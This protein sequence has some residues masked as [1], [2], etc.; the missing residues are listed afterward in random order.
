M[1][2]KDRSKYIPA[3]RYGWLTPLYD[4]IQRWLFRE[5]TFKA[6]L[7]EE[8]RIGKSHRVLD[9]GCGTATL[10]LL[11]KQRHPE[12]E[13]VGLDGDP[14]VLA[15]ARAKAARASAAIAF[16]QGLAFRLPYPDGSFDRVLSSLMFHHLTREH[17]L[18]A[19]QEV[20]RV[21]RPAGEFLLAD[22]GKPHN[23]L[24]GLISLLMR[25]MEEAADNIAGLIPWMLVDSGFERVEEARRF[26]LPYGTLSLYRAQKPLQSRATAPR[27]VLEKTAAGNNGPALNGA[28]FPIFLPRPLDNVLIIRYTLPTPSCW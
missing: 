26:A 5:S 14:W 17:K 7:V 21:L 19:M 10:T 28:G 12:A 2:N 4:P 11:V 18:R 16:D 13:V 15:I 8:A 25:R 27:P 20:L 24:M 22:L 1:K 3:L 6:R 9:L 23:P